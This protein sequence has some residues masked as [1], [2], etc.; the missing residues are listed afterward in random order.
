MTEW[1]VVTVIVVLVGLVAAIVKPL[2]NLNTVITRLSTVVDTLE[3]NVSGLTEKNSEA[4]GKLWGKLEEQD[5]KIGNH[6]TRIQIIEKQKV[7]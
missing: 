4:H 6:E 2:I 5:D 1:T 3:K 7:R